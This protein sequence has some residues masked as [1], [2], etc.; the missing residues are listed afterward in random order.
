MQIN[1][2]EE[3]PTPENLERLSLVTWKSK[4]L[5]AHYDYAEVLKLKSDIETKHPHITVGWW[6][7]L[8][9]S[10]WFSPFSEQHEM[11]KVFQ[12]LK[13]HTGSKLDILIDLEIPQHPLRFLKRVIGFRKRK[14]LIKEFLE[15][16]P[17]ETLHIYTAEYPYTNSFLEKL[18]TFFGVSYRTT[19]HTRLPMCYSSMLVQFF[20]ETAKRKVE[21]Y[22]GQEIQ[23]RPSEF[24]VGL[25]TIAVG[26]LG[27]ERIL[28]PEKLSEDLAWYKS[29]NTKE[30]FIFRLGG[31][32]EK[33]TEAIQPHL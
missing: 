10:Y 4:L 14:K 15:T 26:V 18:W 28:A 24:A 8:H 32:T 7:L 19:K 17:T 25:G 9:T 27:N 16:C 33:Y 11:E 13:T 2:F 22:V 5:I 3:Y 23:K 21:R 6:P 30:V 12:T 31:L 20:G 29:H 1:F